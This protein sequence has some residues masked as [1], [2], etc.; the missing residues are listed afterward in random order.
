MRTLFLQAPTFDGFDGGLEI[1]Y[2]IERVKNPENRDSIGSSA[3]N[4]CMHDIIGV[5]AITQQILAAQ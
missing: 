3:L 5:M 4:K 2:I 1:A